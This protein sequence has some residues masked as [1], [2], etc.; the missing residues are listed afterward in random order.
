MYDNLK[1]RLTDMSVLASTRT[2]ADALKYIEEL[3]DRLNFLIQPD[4]IFPSLSYRGWLITDESDG[5]GNFWYVYNYDWKSG[6]F[7]DDK[8]FAMVSGDLS[9]AIEAVDR[10]IASLTG[11]KDE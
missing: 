6:E 7:D 11:G 3:E 1:E 10:R 4:M 8:N 9:D 2:P 5:N